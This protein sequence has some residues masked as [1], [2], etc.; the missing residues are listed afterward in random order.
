MCISPKKRLL[1]FLAFICIVYPSGCMPTKNTQKE[2]ANQTQKESVNTVKDDS[3]VVLTVGDVRIT[4]KEL[5]RRMNSLTPL[6]QMRYNQETRKQ[7]F[8]DSV[9][10]FELLAK[11]AEERGHGTHPIVQE[12]VKQAMIRS[13]IQREIRGLVKMSDVSDEDVKSYYEANKNKYNRPEQ[14]RLSAIFFDQ[15]AQAIAV[16]KTLQLNFKAGPPEA[17][18]DAFLKAVEAQS[19]DAQTKQR[20]GDL[21]L[22]SL[23]D[24]VTDV[25]ANPLIQA[26]LNTV[27]GSL[28]P[29]VIQ[30]GSR[31]VVA[32]K[33]GQRR[34]FS[35]SLEEVEVEIK[36]TLF[37]EK[38][39][40]ALDKF[41]SDLKAKATITIDQDVLKKVK[42]ERQPSMLPQLKNFGQS[43]FKNRTHAH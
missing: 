2:T 9:I 33:T 28:L 25:V 5:E 41:V 7:E 3:P 30:V 37:K 4:Q 23:G 36:T 39:S 20:R 15:E 38:K 31:W 12:T 17:A 42:I 11:Y 24:K 34:A 29:S 8:I 35:R 43:P 18:R 1:L 27:K 32:Y 10:R 40:Q 16:F 22:L 14:V 6:T 26:G 13:L 21:G 19:V